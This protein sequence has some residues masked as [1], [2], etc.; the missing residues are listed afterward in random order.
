MFIEPLS[1]GSPDS[2]QN[3]TVSGRN[4]TLG[5]TIMYSCTP[6]HALVGN[7]TRTCLKSGLW[8]DSAPTCKCKI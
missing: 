8:S 4:Y 6:G 1:C 2:L 3:T 7:A 5:A